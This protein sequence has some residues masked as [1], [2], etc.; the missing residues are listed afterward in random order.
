MTRE[1]KILPDETELHKAAA[2]E[3]ASLSKDAIEKHGKFTVALCGGSTPRGA[4]ALI[5]DQQPSSPAW[6]NIEMFFGDERNVPPD[7]KD[8][9]FRMANEAMLSKLPL[10]AGNIHRMEGELDANVA[11]ARYEDVL[12]SAFKLQGDTFPRFDLIFLGIGE[13]GH[14]ASL[15]PGT[16]ALKE[17]S[18]LV[19][20]N[21]V[22]KLKTNRITFTFPVLNNAAVVMILVSGAKKAPILKQIFTS[23]DQEIPVQRVLPSHGRLLWL[24]DQA[25]AQQLPAAIS[26]ATP[27]SL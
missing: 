12:R 6:K 9:N 3:F 13:E 24:L 19:V 25:A 16:T 2:Q 8:S 14:T 20:G 27:G 10:P 11:A 1:I 7:D 22:E 23:A 5:A 18:R 4:Y 21:W 26:S 17:N 15:F